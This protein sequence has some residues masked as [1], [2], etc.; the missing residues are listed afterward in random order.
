MDSIVETKKRDEA[1]RRNRVADVLFDRLRPYAREKGGKFILF[2]SIARGAARFDSDVDVLVDFPREWE[3]PAWRLVEDIC[4]EMGVEA[5]VRPV[6][7]CKPEFLSRVLPG[8]K[9]IG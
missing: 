9:V 1:A 8:S 3:S 6:G 5:D 2:G 7:W 4:A